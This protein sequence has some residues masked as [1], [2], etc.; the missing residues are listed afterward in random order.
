MLQEATRFFTLKFQEDRCS[1]F[2]EGLFLFIWK[3]LSCLSNHAKFRQNLPVFS[4]GEI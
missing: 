4:K 1:V 2:E 3:E